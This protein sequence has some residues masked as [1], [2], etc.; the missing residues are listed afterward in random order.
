MSHIKIPK[1][2][3]NRVRKFNDFVTNKYKGLDE[4]E[5]LA[6]LP[7]TIRYEVM[8]HLLSDM[9]LAVEV[10]PQTEVGLYPNLLKKFRF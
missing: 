7:S 1:N 8:D 6:D 4:N 3:I 9:L 5:V 10:F 2:I